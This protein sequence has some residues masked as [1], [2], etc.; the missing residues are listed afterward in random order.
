M[1][2]FYSKEKLEPFG[3][4]AKKLASTNW[5]KEKLNKVLTFE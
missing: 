2:D 4:T 3:L 1:K 5:M